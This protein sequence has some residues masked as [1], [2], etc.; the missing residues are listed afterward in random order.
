MEIR[1]VGGFLIIEHS[2]RRMALTY[3]AHGMQDLLLVVNEAIVH[4][5]C[6]PPPP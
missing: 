2:L 5:S 1:F 6:G 4:K 3:Y